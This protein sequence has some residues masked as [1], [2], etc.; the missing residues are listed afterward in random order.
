MKDG[1]TLIELL[2]YLVI[3]AIIIVL[4]GEVFILFVSSEKKIE[5]RK[6]VE[7]NL[8]I[9][10][11]KITQSIKEASD[12]SGDYPSNTLSLNN[13]TT[14]YTFENGVLK[15]DGI[16]ITSDKVMVATTSDFLFY[17]LQADETTKPGVQIKMR[18]NYKSGDPKLSAISAETQTSVSLR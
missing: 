4:V 12:I 8:D 9:A 16:S 15:K 10:V 7:K 2:I 3:L 17:K 14:T 11:K 13:A 6:E 5:A 1:F 18:V